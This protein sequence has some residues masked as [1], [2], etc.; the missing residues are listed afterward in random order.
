MS[1]HTSAESRSSG[2]QDQMV[3]PETQGQASDR[4]KR[5]H[6][7]RI[8]CCPRGGLVSRLYDAGVD[9]QDQ[10]LFYGLSTEL[11]QGSPV[12]SS[13]VSADSICP[14]VYPNQ[15]NNKLGY[16]GVYF[17]MYARVK[18][19]C[20]KTKQIKASVSPAG[21]RCGCESNQPVPS[22]TY[23]SRKFVKA[24]YSSQGNDFSLRKETHGF[25]L[26][27]SNSVLP[28]A[29]ISLGVALM[30]GDFDELCEP[31]FQKKGCRVEGAHLRAFLPYL[32]H[33]SPRN[34]TGIGWEAQGA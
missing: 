14:V 25:L 12:G 34:V 30:K 28:A 19:T 10:P 7:P 22:E 29:F 15:C 11:S 32:Q 8:Q 2:S 24:L 16:K 18:S 27:A 33:T 6:E 26:T 17:S 20:Y 4:R 9:R 31:P 3:C 21:T 5:Q 1:L 13:H 23:P